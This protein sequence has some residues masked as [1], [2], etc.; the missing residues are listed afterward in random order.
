MRI[1]PLD[2]RCGLCDAPPGQRCRWLHRHTDGPTD[3]ERRHVHY[4][5]R[6]AAARERDRLAYL[7]RQRRRVQG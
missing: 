3:R 2:M 4:T 1:A 6:A 5:R 7:D